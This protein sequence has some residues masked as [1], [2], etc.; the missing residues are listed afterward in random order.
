M[1]DLLTVR[2]GGIG[3]AYVSDITPRHDAD[4]FGPLAA[5]GILAG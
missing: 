5:I 1:V 3:P 4:A 2:G